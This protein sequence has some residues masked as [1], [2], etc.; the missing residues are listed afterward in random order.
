MDENQNFE[1]IA[2]G[3]ETAF[4]LKPKKQG[5]AVQGA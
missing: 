3:L 1:V 4:T 5:F 2:A